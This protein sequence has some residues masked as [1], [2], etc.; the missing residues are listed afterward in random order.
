M[1]SCDA[2]AGAYYDSQQTTADQDC[3]PHI[4]GPGNRFHNL[5]KCIGSKWEGKRP[6]MLKLGRKEQLNYNTN[7][8]IGTSPGEELQ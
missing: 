2:A 4:G 8:I 5:A 1:G 6:T 3:A 7:A